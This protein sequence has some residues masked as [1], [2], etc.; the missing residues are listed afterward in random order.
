ME[1]FSV[2]FNGL[3][4]VVKNL[5]NRFPS[6]CATLILLV[7]GDAGFAAGLG[8]K[9]GGALEGAALPATTTKQQIEFIGRIIGGGRENEVTWW[10]S[11]AGKMPTQSSVEEKSVRDWVRLNKERMISASGDLSSFGGE[12]GLGVEDYFREK[13]VSLDSIGYLTRYEFKMKNLG[14][15]TGFGVLSVQIEKFVPKKSV[16]G[17]K[18]IYYTDVGLDFFSPENWG[19][20]VRARL[21]DKTLA[22]NPFPRM[23][24][25]KS[26]A[27]AGNSLRAFLV[28][29]LRNDKNFCRLNDVV[30]GVCVPDAGVAILKYY[31]LGN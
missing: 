26:R 18:A 6:I 17:I 4:K 29:N 28:P 9:N 12:S 30:S 23:Y 16:G 31:Y 13:G 2:I 21:A 20:V 5:K 10:V 11:E 7:A 25:D 14:R 1:Y 22:E 3:M 8:A 15:L 27:A 19:G 24:V